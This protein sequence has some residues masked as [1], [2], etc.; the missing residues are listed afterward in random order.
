MEYIVE[1]KV[2]VK[3]ADIMDD[4]N[5]CSLLQ[6]QSKAEDKRQLLYVFVV[7]E[8]AKRPPN[9]SCKKGRED[10]MMT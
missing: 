3:L 1:G 7:P 8:A 4:E 6:P 9:S 10:A 5:F 2:T